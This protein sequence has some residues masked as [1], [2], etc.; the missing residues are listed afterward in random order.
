MAAYPITESA[1]MTTDN[2]IIRPMTFTSFAV[3]RCIRVLVEG[4]GHH[5]RP[6]DSRQVEAVLEP[7]AFNNG[8]GPDDRL[9]L[10]ETEVNGQTFALVVELDSDIDVLASADTDPSCKIAYGEYGGVWW[11]VVGFEAGFT[12]EPFELAGTACELSAQCTCMSLQA[13]LAPAR[14]VVSMKQEGM[15]HVVASRPVEMVLL[16]CDGTEAGIDNDKLI[17]NGAS[18]GCNNPVAARFASAAVAIG[19]VDKIWEQLP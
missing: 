18:V 16:E 2:E 11:R 1:T 10:I 19:A 13:L 12:N 8:F 3:E 15:P 17:I 9:S 7:V 5:L 6:I 4:N 14:V